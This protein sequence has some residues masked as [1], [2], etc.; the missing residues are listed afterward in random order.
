MAMITPRNGSVTI[1]SGAMQQM[2]QQQQQSYQQQANPAAQYRAYLEQAG[3]STAAGSIQ[4]ERYGANGSMDQGLQDIINADSSQQDSMQILVASVAQAN[5]WFVN[6][7][8]GRTGKFYEVYRATVE[9]FKISDVT[10]KPCPVRDAFVKMFSKH[11]EFTRPVGM[12]SSIMFGWSLICY[13]RST[14]NDEIPSNQYLRSAEQAIRS[15][16]FMEMVQWLMKTVEGQE[17]ARQLPMDL[18]GKMPNLDSYIGVIDTASSAFGVNNPYAGVS[19]EVTS[20]VRKD[21][22]SN[23]YDTYTAEKLYGGIAG[24][25]TTQ[26]NY[27]GEDATAKLNAM[28]ARN[29]AEYNRSKR[30]TGSSNYDYNEGN[31]PYTAY[32]PI[33]RKRSDYENITPQNRHE[34]KAVEYLNFTGK[35]NHYVLPECDWQKIKAGFRRHPDQGREETVLH[36]CFRIVIIDLELDDGWFSTVLRTDKYDMRTILTNPEKLLPLLED[37][38]GDGFY[39]VVVKTVEEVKADKTLRIEVEE[40]R[41]LEKSIP[42]IVFNEAIVTN[43]AEDITGT[44]NTVSKRLTKEIKGINGVCYNTKIWDTY[45]CSGSSE[46]EILFKDIPFLFRDN[47]NKQPSFFNACKTL[48]SYFNT[49][50]VSDELCEFIDGHLTQLINNYLINNA[51]YDSYPHEKGFLSVDSIIDDYDDLDLEFEQNDPIMF[52]IFNNEDGDHYLVEALKIFTYKD[53]Y[54]NRSDT[55]TLVEKIQ[56]EQELVIERPLHI[57]SV[58]NSDGP[59]YTKPN[60]PVLMKRSQFPEYFELVER[61]FDKTMG[62]VSFD[63]TDKLIH[64]VN[65]NSL[66]LF[67]H[68]AIDKNVATLRHI[69]PGGTLVLLEVD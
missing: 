40:A 20:P 37:P 68:S 10:L 15:I 47:P 14:G 3:S 24:F 25:N 9:G 18:K 61:S 60:E 16:L 52:G 17:H 29:A 65:S 62:D 34:F 69:K 30:S 8:L 58:S 43:K 19:F 1:P 54:L 11:Q 27:S 39:S 66:W 22:A 55:A 46:K 41:K 67:S 21:L 5:L 28:I 44:I 64:F 53:A 7:V 38:E 59:T 45:T 33:K 26:E 50:R 12:N 13:K 6:Q 49:G 35:K 4:W 2:Q 23:Q 56:A 51:G 57:T 48:K 31:D 32:E 36:H 42:A 63:G